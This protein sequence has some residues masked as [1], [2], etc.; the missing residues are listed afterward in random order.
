MDATYAAIVNAADGL[1]TAT[2]S[3]DGRKDAGQAQKIAG[4]AAI[5]GT[6]G[7]ARA[8]G[9]KKS[10]YGGEKGRR[11]LRREVTVRMKAYGV[12]GARDGATGTR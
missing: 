10:Q 6:C 11:N 9:W 2:V 4:I 3:E 7:F 1:L 12:A 8:L 5:F